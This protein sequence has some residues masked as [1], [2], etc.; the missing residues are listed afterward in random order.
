MSHQLERRRDLN[1]DPKWQLNLRITFQTDLQRG[2]MFP[3]KRLRTP[4]LRVCF[5]II[6]CFGLP[7]RNARL[8]L[9]FQGGLGGFSYFQS[10]LYIPFI[11]PPGILWKASQHMK[12]ILEV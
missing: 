2:L 7:K 4:Q 5:F 10:D 12:G 6:I 9:E 1:V 3:S 11:V 8:I